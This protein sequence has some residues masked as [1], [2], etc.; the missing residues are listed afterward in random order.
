MSTPTPDDYRLHFAQ[1]A[2]QYFVAGR[3][4]A[5]DR[6]IP[7]LGNLLHHAV[8][9]ALKASLAPSYSMSQM[10]A[11]GHSLPR[12]WDA[13]AAAYPSAVTLTHAAT[14]NA[15]HKFEELRYPD[16][17]AQKGA[18]MQ[19][20]L[21]R[22]HATTPTTG[23]L[24][25]PSYILVLEDVDKLIEDVFSAMNLSPKFFTGSLSPSAKDHLFSS[26]LHAANWQ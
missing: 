7:V 19:L 22:A 8:E 11:L 6:L 24:N 25:V 17:M 18:N 23:T 5:L 4:A 20:V 3:A 10:K 2:V 13:F 12:L 9:M 1:L 14:I 26:N 21:L 15:L 16:S